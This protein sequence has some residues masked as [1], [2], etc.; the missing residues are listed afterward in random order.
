MK[1]ALAIPA[2]SER[3]SGVLL[4]PTSLPGPHGSG[5]L[6]P[7][8]RRFV[9]FLHESGQSWWQMLPASPTGYGH[10]PYMGSSAFAGNPEWIS[11]ETLRDEG[12]L[13]EQDLLGALPPSGPR[14]DFEAASSFRAPRLRRAGE[15]FFRRDRPEDRARFDAFCAGHARWLDDFTLYQAL[16][17][18]FGGCPWTDWPADLRTRRPAALAEAREL[19]AAEIRIETFLQYEFARQWSALRD[20]CRVRGVGL[21][22]DVPIYVAQ[23]SADVWSNQE[24]FQ[25]RPDGAPAFVAGV[26]PDYFS[27]TGQRWG[28][29]LF[30]WERMRDAGYDWWL[31][32]LGRAFGLFDA[33]RLDHFIGFVRYWEIPAEKETAVEG[34]W[35]DGPGEHFLRAVQEELGKL[36]IIAE[37]LG[38]VTPEVRALRD[39]F[40]LPGMRVLQFAFHGDP[41]RNDHLPHLHPVRCVVYTGTHDNDTTV[42]WRDELARSAAAGDAEAARALDYARRYA[43]TDGH[44]LH[45][46]LI[47]LAHASVAALA[48]VPMQDLLG[49]GSASRMNRPSEPTGNWDW[50]MEDGA[51]DPRLTER[52]RAL[53]ETYVRTPPRN[54]AVDWAQAG[55]AG[56]TERGQAGQSGRTGHAGQAGQAGHAGQPGRTAHAGQPGQTGQAGQPGQAGH[57]GQPGQTGHAG[58]PGQTGHAGQPGRLGPGSQPGQTGQAG[59]A[60]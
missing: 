2:L 49:L 25:L 15:E 23:E 16:R 17:R 47:R 39:R 9:D 46:D 58:R 24:Q 28:H 40:E 41:R 27:Q 19:L 1:N 52:L 48:I 10:S 43:G 55:Q 7:A 35:V 34:R 50:R 20:H 18:H 42:G 57:A 33:V 38:L 11:L 37:D 30:H 53:T 60:P 26:P 54:G 5:D 12:L 13:P 44:E 6:G 32:R 3:R 36:P 8:A 22:G 45:W 14:L 29:P 59:W 21:I 4:H 51:I 31:A 56:E